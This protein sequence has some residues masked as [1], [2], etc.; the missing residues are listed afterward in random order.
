MK[1]GILVRVMMPNKSFLKFIES[2][3]GET[4]GEISDYI[5]QSNHFDSHKIVLPLSGKPA[6][7]DTK[8]SE[9]E[10]TH[11]VLHLIIKDKFDECSQ[12]F[13]ENISKLKESIQNEHKQEQ[14]IKYLTSSSS[15]DEHHFSFL[16]SDDDDDIM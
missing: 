15:D 6:L 4:F 3:P 8:L 11:N 9:M 13:I 1:T 10:L 7:N 16:S 14:H 5:I 2:T 12:Q